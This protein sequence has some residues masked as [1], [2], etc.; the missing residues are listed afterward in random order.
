MKQKTTMKKAN[1]IKAII[2]LALMGILFAGYL[3]VYT[4]IA[5]QPGCDLF[6][7][8]MPSC[9][10]GLIMY[11]IVFLLALTLSAKAATRNKRNVA[12]SVISFI[13][14]LFSGFLT[15]Y[16]LSAAS[17]TKLEIFGVPPCVYGLVMY[18]ALFALALLELRVS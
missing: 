15:V 7:F 2:I 6:F 10:Y 17:C 5:G 9:F 11:V 16:I 3:T 12:M 4:L 13:G 18:L 14:I 1:T 8:G